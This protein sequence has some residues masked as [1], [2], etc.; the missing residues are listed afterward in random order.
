M[1]ENYC[2]WTVAPDEAAVEAA[3]ATVA[4]ARGVGLFKE[5][6]VWT[7]A[8]EIEGATC[9]PL[10]NWNS[11]GGLFR[12]TYLRDAVSTLPFE[13]V[14]WLDP[15]TEFLRHPGSLLRALRRAPVHVPLG[16]DLADPAV[17]Q[18][19]WGGAPCGEL[20]RRMQE[21]GVI[22]R[23]VLAAYPGFF[24]VHRGAIGTFYRLAFDFWHR[25]EA[26]GLALSC[27][28]LLAYAAQMLTGDPRRHHLSHGT[29]LWLPRAQAEER[30]GKP[31]AIVGI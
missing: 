18:E 31:S 19:A 6:H 4:S 7:E 29:D 12:F 3:R 24:I 2:F 5:F 27:E 14:V 15:G 26:A 25:C 1:K 13:H 20:A 23:L 10:G 28:P 17:A 21:A 8:P 16:F 22:G 9:H 11:W 30:P